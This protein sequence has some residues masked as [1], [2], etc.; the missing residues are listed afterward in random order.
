MAARLQ[1]ESL[2][3]GCFIGEGSF[4]SILFAT[5]S[6]RNCTVETVELYSGM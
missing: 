5:V 3:S 1:A 2:R 4:G 6:S